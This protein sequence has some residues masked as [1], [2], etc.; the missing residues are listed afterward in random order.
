MYMLT[1]PPIMGVTI[2]PPHKLAYWK[3]RMEHRFG[4]SVPERTR[5]VPRSW[6]RHYIQ[7][8]EDATDEAV[9]LYFST[10]PKQLNFVNPYLIMLHNPSLINKLLKY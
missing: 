10:L 3:V 2:V 9:N 4:R 6:L 7:C 1:G 5:G 8:L